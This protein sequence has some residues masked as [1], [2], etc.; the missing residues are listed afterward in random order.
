[1]VQYRQ[2]RGYHRKGV[3]LEFKKRFPDMFRDYEARCRA[4]EV[5]LGRRVFFRRA[6]EPWILNFLLP[7]STGDRSQTCGMSSPGWSICSEHYKK[8]GIT[9]LEVPPLGCGNGQLKWRVVG[10]TLSPIFDE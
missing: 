8:W 2:L 6:V 9:S 4:G 10:P 3:A 1:M 5:R 7:N